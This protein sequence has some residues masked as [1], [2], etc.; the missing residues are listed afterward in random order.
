ML[1]G[2]G[3]DFVLF[4]IEFFQKSIELSSFEHVNDMER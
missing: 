3:H 2:L 1:T 4:L